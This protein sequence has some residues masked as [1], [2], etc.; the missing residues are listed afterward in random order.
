MSEAEG[1][2]KR[3][4]LD[5]SEDNLN[6]FEEGEVMN[7]SEE[8]IEQRK[9]Q[10]LLGIEGFGSTKNSHV[11]DNSNTAACGGRAPKQSRKARQYMNQRKPTKKQAYE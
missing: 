8:E 2:S 11:N 10:A 4:R 3:L 5:N 7:G 1:E 6:E 9:I